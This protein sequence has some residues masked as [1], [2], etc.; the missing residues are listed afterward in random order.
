M[1]AWFT[2]YYFQLQI[3]W[4]IAFKP[5]VLFDR[6][7]QLPWYQNTLQQWI[8]DQH[9][10]NP[11]KVLEVG[12]A[13]GSLTAY[14]ASL[15][16]TPTGVDYSNKMVKMAQSLHQ[17]LDFSEANVLDLPFETNYFDA[18]IAASLL[19]IVSD[20]NTAM[21]ELSRTCKKGGVITVLVPAAN[22][23]DENLQQLQASID[24]TGFSIA[25]MEAW[26]KRAPKMEASDIVA[27]FQQS[28]LIE[29][30]TKEYLQGMVIAVSATK[31]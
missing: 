1:I 14:I 31:L 3:Q 5:A 19:N 25:A 7:N 21:A 22:F 9:F 28:Q 8:N 11:C 17:E 29:I 2:K 10:S 12:C 16:C 26:H 23:N 20:K 18:V 27:L 15:G 4:L 24:D 13:T 30:N 6:I